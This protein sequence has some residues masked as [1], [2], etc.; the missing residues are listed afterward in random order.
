MTLQANASDPD[1][2]P[3][4]YSWR[5][6]VGPDV[7]ALSG[8]TPSVTAPTEPTTLAFELSVSNAPETSVQRTITVWVVR[9]PA[10]TIW[11]SPNGTDTNA[12]TRAAPLRSVQAGIN[13]AASGG[14]DVYLAVGTYT[15]LVTLRNGVSIYGGYE[16]AT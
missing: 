5:Q 8:P 14:G 16:A 4:T 7:G 3:L 12:G 10:R 15:G 13:A 9:N 1:G 2:R 6:L 11:V